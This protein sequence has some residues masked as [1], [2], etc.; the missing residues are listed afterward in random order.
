MMNR[1]KYLIPLLFVAV[2]MATIQPGAVR[3][4][5]AESA[6]L[7]VVVADVQAVH[8]TEDA[9]EVAASFIGLLSTLQETQ[10]FVFVG[11]E[12][13]SRQVGPFSASD[14]DY[15]ESRARILTLL[16]TVDEQSTPLAGLLLEAQAVLSREQGAPGSEVYVITGDS[17][18]TDFGQLAVQL[19]PLAGRFD[20]FGW[21][22]NGVGLPNASSESAL[23][24]EG[25]ASESAGRVIDL[26]GTDA[27]MNVA[28]SILRRV[29]RG[30]LSALGRRDL[31]PSELMNSAISIVPGTSETT[32]ILFR[33]ETFGEMQLSNPLGFGVSAFDQSKFQIVETPHAIIWKLIDPEPGNWRVDV[34]GMQGGVSVWRHTA[35]DYSLALIANEP[36][37]LNEPA[38]ILAYVQ[39][40]DQ[41]VNLEDVRMYTNITT[42]EGSRVTL[43]MMDDG[44]GSDAVEGDGSFT[45]TLPPL[46]ERGEYQVELELDWLTYNHRISSLT[47]FSTSIFPGLL[48][49]AV[50][51]GEL[52]PGARTHVANVVVHVDGQAYP[53]K[54]ETLTANLSSTQDE[55]GVIELVPR[56][57]Y[58]DGPAFEYDV[59]L[60]APDYGRF[61]VSYLLD[62]E[63]AG[64][65]FQHSTD[66]AFF[67]AEPPVAVAEV[68][69]EVVVEIAPAVTLPSAVQSLPVPIISD[70][71]SG[72]PMLAV[73]IPIGLLVV[74][75]AGASWVLTR[76][77]PYG[78][79]YD[80]QDD[81]LVDF[82]AIRRHP[83][84]ELLLR[85][86]VKG[87]ELGLPGLEGVVF[88][89]SKGHIQITSQGDYP[90]VRV[91]NQPL[92]GQTTIEDRTWIGTGGKLYT[93]L[94]SPPSPMLEGS[95]D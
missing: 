46:L 4:V 65:L 91:N 52:E 89:F 83:V 61:S 23:F 79:I 6:P 82:A 40:G 84:L 48:V 56:R 94:V 90:T 36:V 59:F 16:G 9:V 43:E 70:A 30:S 74:L 25:L 8:Q 93:F 68:L 57:V 86:S 15:N 27:L 60:T 51:F 71:T 67:I 38:A 95:S 37:P 26:S 62:T 12:D 5:S 77:R 66:A 18:E 24:L 69:T 14:P 47:S 20:E 34:T 85:G 21:T 73:W 22:I 39:R 31:D 45:L 76:T 75:G 92:V 29:G 11:G 17:G 10:R 58:G 1:A 53:V 28:D 33:D 19:S 54:P 7:V 32:I 55:P 35:N 13:P 64:R 49:T 72:F 44:I 2:A 63:Y 3:S 78:F 81:P 88:R 42:P 41:P 80:D 87:N 50:D